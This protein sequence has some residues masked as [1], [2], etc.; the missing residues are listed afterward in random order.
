MEGEASVSAKG[1]ATRINRVLKHTPRG[2][3]RF[4]R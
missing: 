2:A 3:V 4:R 1:N